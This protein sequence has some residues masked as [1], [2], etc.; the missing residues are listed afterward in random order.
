MIFLL[1]LLGLICGILL[2]GWIHVLV[3]YLI[4]RAKGYSCDHVAGIFIRWQRDYYDPD[5]PGKMKFRVTRMNQTYP[6]ILMIKKPADKRKK[7][8]CLKLV[9]FILLAV[10]FIALSIINEVC[11]YDAAGKYLGGFITGVFIGGAVLFLQMIIFEVRNLKDPTGLRAKILAIRDSLMTAETAADIVAEPFDFVSYANASLSDKVNY[12]HVFFF[13]AEIRNDL[14]AM[15][16]CISEI[17]KLNT[18]GLTDTG[19]FALD[20]ILFEYYSFRHK[21][22]E[23][24]TRYYQH[25]KKNID[26]DTDFNGRRRLAYYSFYILGDREAARRYMDEGFAALSVDDPRHLKISRV[27]E[28]KMLRYLKSQLD[29]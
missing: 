6:T 23:L 8:T 24:A 9:I 7:P 26:N 14:T 12:L 21:I 20:G 13:S 16:V 27:Y 5:E 25:S 1:E 15:S 29:A 4:Y 2:F 28:E 17:T 18:I 11:W 10:V 3:H 22:P 19:H